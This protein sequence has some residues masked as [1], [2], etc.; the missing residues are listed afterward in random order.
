MPPY[1]HT[2]KP[3]PFNLSRRFALLAPVWIVTIAVVL[4]ALLDRFMTQQL[5]RH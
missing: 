4:C 1:P 3:V 5:L 2:G